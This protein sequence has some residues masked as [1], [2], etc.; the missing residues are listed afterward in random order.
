MDRYTNSIEVRH[1]RLVKAI[2]ETGSITRAADRLHLTQPALSH[3]LTGI[4]GLLGIQLFTRTKK[5]MIP[6]RAGEMV[7][8]A[9]EAVLGEL[10]GVELEISKLVHGEAGVLRIGTTCVFSYKWLPRVMKK[11]HKLFPQVDVELKTSLDVL[12]DLREHRLDLV[13][14]TLC[15]SSPNLI[16]EPIFEDEIVITLPAKEP[17]AAKPFLNIPDFEGKDLITYT[18]EVK[19][20]LY[21]DYL[22]PAGVTPNRVIRADQ[23][24]AALELVKTGFGISVFPRWT[25]RAALEAGEVE[26]RSFTKKGFFME[27]KAVSWSDGDLPAYHREFIRMMR[28]SGHALPS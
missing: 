20:D 24:E 9:A 19:G 5:R 3:Q 10:K 13:I 15:D 26:A 6:T 23:P 14:T 8:H 7:L 18:D 2:A 16:A 17:L 11:F 4:E 25:I 27:W 1:L 28:E 12:A 21:Q 22:A